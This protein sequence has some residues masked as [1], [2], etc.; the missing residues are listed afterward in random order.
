[1]DEGFVFA[2][3][4]VFFPKLWLLK[5]ELRL[6]PKPYNFLRS[7]RSRYIS[8]Y[9][10]RYVITGSPKTELSPLVL[11]NECGFLG[12]PTNGYFTVF[13]EQTTQRSHA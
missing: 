8:I 9:H 1:M 7:G 11:R 6:S 5:T 4:R 10:I 2:K 3:T 12:L 13:Y